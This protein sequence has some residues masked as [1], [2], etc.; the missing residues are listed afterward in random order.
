MNEP[1]VVQ[2]PDQT[3]AQLFLLFHGVGSNAANL[4]PLGERLAAEFP[5]AAV[6]CIDGPH[7]CD[8]G[9]DGR[10]WFSVRG[11]TEENR[12]ERVADCMPSFVDTVS[13]MQAI[14]HVPP[15]ATALIGFS[16]GAIM[17]LESVRLG[18]HLAGR[19][20]ALAGRFALLPECA[21]E[22]S[23]LHLIHGKNDTVIPYLHTVAAAERLIGLGGDVTADVLPFTGHEISPLMTDRM[24]ERLK[25]HVP[26]RVW[27]A[28]QQEAAQL[29]PS[30]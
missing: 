17:S 25:S 20:V 27:N 8:M 3:A 1:I 23:T 15:E 22:H 18:N 24:I 12:I 28:A 13:E 10:E 6:V 4:V 5:Q 2:A 14:Y 21:P 7:A 9:T 29:P 19:V 11:I 26:H 30:A 16:Q